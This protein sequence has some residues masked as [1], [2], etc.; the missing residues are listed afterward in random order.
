M[1]SRNGGNITSEFHTLT[2]D[3]ET[4]TEKD[5]PLTKEEIRKRNGHASKI[6]NPR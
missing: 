3:K 1:A 5:I 6:A 2:S 4:K